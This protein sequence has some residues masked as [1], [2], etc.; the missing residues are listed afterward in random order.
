MI[1]TLKILGHKFSVRK[2]SVRFFSLLIALSLTSL[3]SCTSR[4]TDEE[5][6]DK[7]VKECMKP[8][9]EQGVDVSKAKN[10]CD[11]ALKS[12]LKIDSSYL[13]MSVDKQKQFYEEHEKEIIE[14]CDE[15]K[16]LIAD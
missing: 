9:V 13:K 15:L 2:L 7:N 14:G 16:K 11:C 5:I 6:F 4:K 1:R 8:L 12:I 3:M 10:I